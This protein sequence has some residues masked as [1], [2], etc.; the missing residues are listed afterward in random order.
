MANKVALVVDDDDAIRKAAKSL[1]ESSQ[2]EVI[3]ADTA[4]SALELLRNEPLPDVVLLDWDLPGIS[5]LEALRI[6][7]S[8][9]R[10]AT[11]PIIMFTA[12]DQFEDLRAALEAG[13][14][15]YIMKPFDR[16]I[17]ESKLQPTGVIM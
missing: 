6:L 10:T 15:D 7:R 17:L 16:E 11:L 1:L 9:A 8:E 2:L 13:A 14:T 12:H 3:E 4:E 5:G